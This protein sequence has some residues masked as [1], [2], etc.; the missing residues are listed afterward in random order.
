MLPKTRYRATA[1][2]G[3]KRRRRPPAVVGA[4]GNVSRPEASVE[5]VDRGFM[6]HDF[7]ITERYLELLLG[8][9]VFDVEAMVAGSPL[10]S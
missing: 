10:F 7:A 1:R 8:P 6:I 9:A 3:T 4:D 5:S 2:R